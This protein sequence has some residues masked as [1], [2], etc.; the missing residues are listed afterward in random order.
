MGIAEAN[1]VCF[2]AGLATL[3]YIPVVNTFSFLLCERALDQIRSSVAY[4]KLNVKLAANYGGLSDSYDGASHH[5]ISDLAIIR[6]I[7]DMTLINISDA[8]CARKMLPDIV[9][10]DG[11]V[12]FRLCRA[13]TPIVHSEDD[14]FE[15]GKAKLIREGSDVTIFTTGIMLWR[16]VDAA[17]KLEEEGISAKVV[18]IHTIKPIDAEGVAR[19]AGKTGAALT[20]EEAN[21]L[22]G[23][24]GAVAEILCRE[25]I[26]F[27]DSV[28]IADRFA[29]S[30]GY[31]QLLDK[32]GM[33]TEEI[34]QKC[35]KLV[36]LK[37]RGA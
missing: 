8:V 6:S 21:V 1:M 23:L 37:K 9:Y 19:Y 12:Y 13:E 28:G 29:E 7:P 36:K 26:A 30:G 27:L 5:S 18:E 32:Y 11:P 24:G 33:S 35:R 15:I 25:K 31:E 22:G 14:S 20:V 34:C 10:H 4:N 2:A 3:G 16:A 17:N